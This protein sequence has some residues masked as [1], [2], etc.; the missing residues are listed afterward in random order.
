MKKDFIFFITLLLVPFFAIANEEISISN[1]RDNIYFIVSPQGGNVV[2]SN[3]DDGTF[4]ID[5]QLTNRSELI[6][7]AIQNI[8]NTPIKFILNTHFHFDHT[9]GN[10]YFGAKDAVILA[11]DNVHERLSTKQFIT[12]FK[13]E[14]APLSEE[15]LPKITFSEKMK[16]HYPNYG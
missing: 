14:M 11:H 16:L 13:K 10:E 1:I 3:G 8:N 4:I 7:K 2:A 12:F 5:D 9:G 15:G 6:D